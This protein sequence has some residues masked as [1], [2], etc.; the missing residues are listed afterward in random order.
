MMGCCECQCLLYW[1]RVSARW[2]RVPAV[3]VR[4]VQ[5][6]S[7]ACALCVC[8]LQSQ[9]CHGVIPNHNI[10]SNVDTK[11]FCRSM[12]VTD[13]GIDSDKALVKPLSHARQHHALLAQE[14]LE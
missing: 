7:L 6:F 1:S 3:T 2:S 5:C 4:L 8:W 13:S 12:Q 10:S 14:L 11:Y 9:S